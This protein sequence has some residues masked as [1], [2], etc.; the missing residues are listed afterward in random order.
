MSTETESAKNQHADWQAMHRPTS[1][2]ETDSNKTPKHHAIEKISKLTF[3]A[4]GGEHVVYETKDL[5]W[6]DRVVKI[7]YVSMKNL[8]EENARDHRPLAEITPTW[9]AKYEADAKR[10]EKEFA[11]LLA[12]FGD[13]ALTQETTIA[14]VPV[15]N[16]NI[17]QIYG[18]NNI[19]P[20]G[21]REVRSLPAVVTFQDKVQTKE[22]A[23]SYYLQFGNIDQEQLTQEQITR[24]Q[25][26]FFFDQEKDYKQE[27]LQTYPTLEPF[28][29]LADLDP[30]WRML[31]R[32]FTERLIEYTHHTG[33]AI[34][35]VGKDN[36]LF[37]KKK[38]GGLDYKLI[39]ALLMDPKSFDKEA[40]YFEEWQKNK[41]TDT[42]IHEVVPDN[43]HYL[44]GINAL[45]WLSGSEK[46][47]REIKN[48]DILPHVRS[49]AQYLEESIVQ[50]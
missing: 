25:E 5:D 8:L 29:A 35:L 11:E 42:N 27:I 43:I 24:I 34:D 28:I 38:K 31:M 37:F 40:A 14:L 16:E 18:F 50:K 41:S 46:R 13:H 9:K 49:V 12:Y 45:A 20:S 44:R 7:N 22:H 4:G 47:L 2:Q 33:K 32:D 36:V 3:L 10:R 39:D 30:N 19:P 23:Q 26:D 17:Q 1:T 15:T 48:Q 21:F 6:K